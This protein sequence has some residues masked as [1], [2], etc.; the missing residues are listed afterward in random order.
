MQPAV[1]PSNALMPPEGKAGSLHQ[2]RPLWPWGLAG[3]LEGS[4]G[5]RRC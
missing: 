4:G 3:Q 2:R 5:E 1:G